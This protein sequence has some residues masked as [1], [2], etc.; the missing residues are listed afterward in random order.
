MPNC[1]LLVVLVSCLAAQA[2]QPGAKEITVAESA[3]REYLVLGTVIWAHPGSSSIAIR[4]TSLLGYLRVRE[5]AYRV[6]QPSA[7]LDLRPGDRVTA[8]FSKRD[9]MLHRLRRLQSATKSDHDPKGYP[10]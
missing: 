8:V 3:V 2:V 6:R 5:R 4:G 7:L 1:G 10:Q 9:G